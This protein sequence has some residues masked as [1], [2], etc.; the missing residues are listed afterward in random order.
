MMQFS[1]RPWSVEEDR[2]LKQA[3]QQHG[4]DFELLAEAVGGER[5][6]VDCRV[7]LRQIVRNYWKQDELRKL[8]EAVKSQSTTLGVGN[9]HNIDWHKVAEQVDN[10]RGAT[11]CRVKWMRAGAHR[12]YRGKYSREE[13]QLLNS[14]VERFGQNW[15]EIAR[16]MNHRRSDDQLRQYFK[17]NLII[18]Q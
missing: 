1:R 2:R 6:P 9:N 18:N 17:K 16:R 12:I 4:K 7:R 3:Y 11:E 8:H 15:S 10:G 5:S 14:L 13:I